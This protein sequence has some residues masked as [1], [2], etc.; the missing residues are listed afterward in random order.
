MRDLLIKLLG[1]YK[2]L[3]IEVDHFGFKTKTEAHV[4]SMYPW[5]TILWRLR[6]GRIVQVSKNGTVE[7][8]ECK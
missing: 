5:T 1:G 6:G 7:V 3:V 4:G 8:K 2:F